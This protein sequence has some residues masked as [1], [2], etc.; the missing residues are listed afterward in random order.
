[1]LAVLIGLSGEKSLISSLLATKQ[2]FQSLRLQRDY[3]IF[4]AKALDSF[5]IYLDFA[6][7]FYNYFFLWLFLV[8]ASTILQRHWLA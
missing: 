1:M 6:I 8:L 7:F 3:P 4:I 5:K 2:V